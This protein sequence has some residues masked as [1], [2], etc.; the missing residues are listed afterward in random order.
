MF[1]PLNL[2]SRDREGVYRQLMEPVRVRFLNPVPA[3]P[4]SEIPLLL[5]LEDWTAKSRSA[6][7]SPSSRF[8]GN[9]NINTLSL[10]RMCRGPV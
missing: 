6:V 9:R 2:P 3:V 10:Q 1:H 5:Y 7:P 8:L 4:L